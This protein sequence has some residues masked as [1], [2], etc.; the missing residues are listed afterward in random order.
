[1]DTVIYWM[2]ILLKLILLIVALRWD[3]KLIITGDIFYIVDRAIIWAIFWLLEKVYGIAIIVSGWSFI[4]PGIRSI[5]VKT[6]NLELVS[7]FN[8]L[9][10]DLYRLIS[11]S[12]HFSNI[13]LSLR[14]FDVSCRHLIKVNIAGIH[15]EYY[16]RLTGDQPKDEAKREK[17]KSPSDL[18]HKGKGE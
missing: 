3:T 8:N 15:L 16:K 10:D 7:I 4:S 13:C 17:R 6:T 14:V 18:M 1:M 12:Q 9:F 2:G 11:S 5:S